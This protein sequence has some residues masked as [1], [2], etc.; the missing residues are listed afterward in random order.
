MTRLLER[1]TPTFS[2]PL[3]PKTEEEVGKLK[4]KLG[5]A[6]FRG[7]TATSIFLGLKLIGL[8]VSASSSAA[9]RSC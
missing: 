4:L 3:Q 5:Y 9:V 2:K 6:G 8:L 1:A 7:E